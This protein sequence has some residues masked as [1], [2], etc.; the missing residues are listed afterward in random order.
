[1]NSKVQAA[2]LESE[3]SSA[4]EGKSLKKSAM[5]SLGMPSPTKDLVNW[6]LPS[7]SHKK[8]TTVE[9]AVQHLLDTEK[10][11]LACLKSWDNLNKVHKKCVLEMQVLLNDMQAVEERVIFEVG[12]SKA[13]CCNAIFVLVFV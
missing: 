7:D 13:S 5:H 10:A 11:R 3:K 1:M 4:L 8:H 2:I 12:R 6:L 9:A